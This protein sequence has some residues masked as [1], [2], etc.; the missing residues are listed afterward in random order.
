VPWDDSWRF[1]KEVP[2]GASA[3]L[4]VPELGIAYQVENRVVEVQ[5]GS[6][7]ATAGVQAGDVINEVRFFSHGKKS[8]DTP[9]PES[10]VE[11]KSH[12]WAN[13]HYYLSMLD[14]PK[15]DLKVV[16]DK[17]ELERTLELVPDNTWPQ[18]E[19]GLILM[20]DRRLQKADNFLQAIG[21]GI[22]Q[23]RD[24]IEMIFD[25]LRG[26]ATGRLSPKLLAGP[27]TIGTAAFSI[28]GANI[29]DFIKFLGVI[30]VNL[31]VINFLPIPVLDGGHM[32]FLSYEKLR[33]RPASEQVRVAATY[34]G[35]AF[36]ACLMLFVLS[37]D[38]TR[39]LRGT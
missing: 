22:D 6:P 15:M 5:P 25:N 29:Y 38:V 7:A 3:P 31:A 8:S 24:F 9:R 23:T 33:G 28:A 39:L 36:I 13:I 1:N 14:V 17:V 30:G 10:W 20:P 4:A 35:L 21:M 26:F 18:V 19:R 34:L 11:L 12:Q 32:V 16:R 37:L 27:V 2:L